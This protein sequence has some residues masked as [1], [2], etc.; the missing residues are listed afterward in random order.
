MKTKTS[1]R[2]SVDLV[3][4]FHADLKAGAKASTKTLKKYVKDALAERVHK[5]RKKMEQHS[6]SDADF[7]RDM[8]SIHT[9][10]SQR[11]E[12]LGK[13]FEDAIFDDLVSLYEA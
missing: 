2:V 11:Q 8:T 6:Y 12:R 9:S 4:D 13:E 10:L 3:P 5:D 7:V 1:T